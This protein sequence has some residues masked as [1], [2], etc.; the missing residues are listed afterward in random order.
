MRPFDVTLDNLVHFTSPVPG[1]GVPP[2]GKHVFG[3]AT[4]DEDGRIQI[5]IPAQNVFL[6]KPGD[7]LL[8]L[9]DESQGLALMRESDIFKR[10]LQPFLPQNGK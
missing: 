8:V 5:P 9:G 1:L 3:L 2:R 10:L 7:R 4:M 6:L